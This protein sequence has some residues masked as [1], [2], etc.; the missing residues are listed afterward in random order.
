MRLHSDPCIRETLD[1]S[2]IVTLRST[3][4]YPSSPPSIESHTSI[5][6]TPPPGAPLAP[7][8]LPTSPGAPHS[9][10]TTLR[11][12]SRCAAAHHSERLRQRELARVREEERDVRRR[13]Q[14]LRDEHQQVRR[15]AQ[16]VAP[17]P[18]AARILPSLTL[19]GL[20]RTPSH[21]PVPQLAELERHREQRRWEQEKERLVHHLDANA[22]ECAAQHHSSIELDSALNL[23]AA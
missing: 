12:G 10:T 18:Q 3:L 1:A 22:M 7:W 17:P 21:P 11:L 9:L 14:Q 2:C 4:T 15:R 6:H 13:L 5:A 8:P 23:G 16:Q 19:Q 20:L